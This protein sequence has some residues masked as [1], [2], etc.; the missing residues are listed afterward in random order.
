[1]IDCDALLNDLRESDI[2]GSRSQCVAIRYDDDMVDPSETEVVELILDA[3]SVLRE[4]GILFVEGPWP[5][6]RWVL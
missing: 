5:W 1:M 4:K 3:L 2:T 6:C